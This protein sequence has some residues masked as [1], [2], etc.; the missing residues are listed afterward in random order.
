MK[1]LLKDNVYVEEDVWDMQRNILVLKNT[2]VDLD[3]IEPTPHSPDHRATRAVPYSYD[4][5]A[6]APTWER[7]LCDRLSEEER[8]FFQ[9]FAG[10]CLTH[11]TKQQM[12]LW[13]VGERGCGKS[14]LTTGLQTMLGDLA[15]TLE[16]SAAGERFGL[17]GI[18]GKTL[19]TCTEVPYGHLKG[20]HVLNALITGDAVKVEDK[21]KKPYDHR[22]TA[23]LMWSMNNLP[24][25]YDAGN[26]IFRRAKILPIERLAP[27]KRDSDVI[28]RVKLEGPG[29][30]NWALE[31]LRRLNERGQFDYPKSILRATEEFRNDNDLQA[32]FLEDDAERAPSPQVFYTDEYMVFAE[33]LTQAFN[34]W[35]AANGHKATGTTASLAKDWKRLGLERGKR[36]SRGFPYYGVKLVRH[37]VPR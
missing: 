35:A 9:E 2:A 23:K 15:G 30:L 7:V 14:T 1:G 19:L 8:T 11:S 18:S 17:S 22:N 25:L 29:I 4:P 13:L 10:Y 33:Q 20:T 6:T 26:G 27:E 37:R 34:A 28:E 21:Y 5:E 31:G 16:P 36:K 3:T 24:G 12:A 32:R